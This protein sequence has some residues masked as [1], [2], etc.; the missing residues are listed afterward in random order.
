[1]VK[2]DGR[3]LHYIWMN[4]LSNAVKFTDSGS[5]TLSVKKQLGGVLLAVIDTGPGISREDQPH[6]FERFR[7]TTLGQQRGGT[8]LGL[9]I[10]RAL[11]EAH[12]G[13]ISVESSVGEGTIFRVFLPAA[14]SS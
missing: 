6:I 12:G 5:I 1:K 9:A 2:A 14:D 10:T 8:G 7:Q 4:L 3:R 13:C 11:V